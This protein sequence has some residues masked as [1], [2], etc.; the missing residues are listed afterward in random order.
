MIQF[1]SA[2]I[3]LEMAWRTAHRTDGIEC[4]H[5]QMPGVG[6]IVDLALQRP[7]KDNPSEEG[8]ERNGKNHHRR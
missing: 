2:S 4:K 1:Q 6:T 7:A 8:N 3:G 5:G